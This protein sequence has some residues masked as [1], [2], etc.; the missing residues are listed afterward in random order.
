MNLKKIVEEIN[1]FYGITRKK[2]ISKI[3]NSLPMIGETSMLATFGE[4]AAVIEQNEDVLL[5]AADGIMEKLINEDPYWAGYCSVLVNIN[6]IAAM[7]GIP[8]AMVNV[9]SVKNEDIC[10]KIMNGMR[11]GIE[12]FGVPIVGGH[13]HPNSNY[14][15]LDITIL[16][17]AKR[18]HVLYS[19]TSKINDDII[20]A[21]DIEGKITPG[22]K[23]SWDTTSF[24]ET[25]IV[26]KQILIMSEIANKNLA[27]SAKDISNPGSL[28]TLGMLLE[29]SGKG[30]IVDLNS[31]PKPKVFDFIHWLK[32]YQG[33]GFVL[34]CIQK[35]SKEVI[36]I[37][38]SVGLKAKVVGKIDDTNKLKITDGKNTEILFDFEKD[39]I[40][41]IKPKC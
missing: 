25:K 7:G 23:Y 29:N 35:N 6:D 37:F 13:T 8:I 26:R 10:M 34:T 19:N 20:F 22:F 41:G 28:G 39:I 40:T 16:G 11:D 17:T 27:N 2:I 4:D 21:M 3:T 38:E 31:I 14:N 24:K 12:K 32:V 30:A 1:S 33:C 5:L 15:A 18:G 36:S 9:I